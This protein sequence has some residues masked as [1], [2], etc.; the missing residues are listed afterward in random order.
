MP[1]YE[2]F[3]GAAASSKTVPG[4]LYVLHLWNEPVEGAGPAETWRA[5]LLNP[6]GRWRRYFSSVATLTAFLSALDPAWPQDDD[7]LERSR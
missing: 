4:H 7:L 3:P 2:S 6:V 5:S 1:D